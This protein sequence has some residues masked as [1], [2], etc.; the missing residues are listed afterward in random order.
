MSLLKT[1]RAQLGLSVTPANNFV[2]DAS[3]NN[4]TMKLARGN[5][6]ATTQDIMTVAA[7]GKVAF[8]QTPRVYLSGEVIQVRDTVDN[9][10]STSSTLWINTTMAVQ[11]ITP[12]STN[13]T[14]IIDLVFLDLVSNAA[15]INTEAQYYMQESG[16][17]VGS[18]VNL[19]APSGAGNTGIVSSV[20]MRAIIGNASLATRSFL[21]FANSPQGVQISALSQYWKIT[22][23][24]N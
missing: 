16:N 1:I 4:G 22:E 14:I 13:S 20:S 10:S 5:A 2:L 12:K 21:L 24:Q 15:S 9:G 11:T 6:G 19:A 17:F 23:V 7:D 18:Q 8:P 3:A